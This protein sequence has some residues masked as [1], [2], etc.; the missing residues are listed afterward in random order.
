MVLVVDNDKVRDVRRVRLALLLLLLLLVVASVSVHP[1]RTLRVVDPQGQPLVAYIAYRY[2]GSTLNPVH[3]VTYDA[4]A[5]A[6]ARTGDDGRVTFPWAVHRHLPFPIQTHSS[7]WAEMVYVP[8][9]HNAHGRFGPG[10]IAQRGVFEFDPAERRVV[11]I[12]VSDRPELWEGTLM[13]LS[14]MIQRLVPKPFRPGAGL[15]GRDAVTADLALELI[16]H[17]RQEYEAFLARHGTVLRPTPPRPAMWNDEEIR[18]WEAMV[19]ADLAAEPTWGAQARRL[20]GTYSSYF[21]EYED[22]LR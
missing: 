10:P 18:R 20:F 19:A 13:N 9:L 16:G 6:L 15:R 11:V 4:S 7:R 17:F 1:R 3:P 8:R 2:Q 14:S 5:L 12:D 22:E 21:R